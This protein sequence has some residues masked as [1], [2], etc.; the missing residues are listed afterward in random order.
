[1]NQQNVDF[2]KDRLFFL[3]FGDN[4]HKELDKK[5]AEKPDKFTL[6]FQGEF[7]KDNSKKTVDYE[8]DL[9]KSKKEDMYFLNNYTA[10][11]KNED[12]NKEK[13]Q[14]FFL[15]KGSGVTAKEA[16]NLLEGRGVFK[17]LTKK[18]KEDAAPDEKPE[19]YDV[20]MQLNF[21]KKDDYGN[22]KLDTYSKAW[23]FDL[24]KNLAKHP[25]KDIKDADQKAELLKSLQK[26]NLNQVTFEREGKEQK[27][28]LSANPR[29]RTV[30]VYDDKMILQ[31]QG[32]RASKSES[33]SESLQVSQDG[34]KKKQENNNTLKSD[35]GPAK[36]GK[37]R[38]GLA[39]H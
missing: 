21:K 10:T 16:F 28:F 4:L 31:F 12:P 11:L 5:L 26:G 36:E 7:G 32:V 1:M 8:I 34:D 33:K 27:M 24:E 20:W 18:K 23:N 35:D 14:K 37:K 29:E 6:S 38:K 3:G 22:N 13:S 2:L 25:I 17:T 19:K 39:V 15:N 9:S 30:N